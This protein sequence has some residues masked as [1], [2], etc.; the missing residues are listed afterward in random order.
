MPGVR[1]IHS[2][3]FEKFLLAVGCVFVRQKGDHRIYTKVGARRPV[4]VCH[5]RELSAF[6]IMSNLRTLR[7]DTKTYLQILESHPREGGDQPWPSIKDF[8]GDTLCRFPPSR[9]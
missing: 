3:E 8:E 2:R 9:E 5:G 1:P 7:I 4:V 6:E